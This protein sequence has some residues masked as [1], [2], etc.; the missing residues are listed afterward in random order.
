MILPTF[1]VGIYQW[2]IQNQWALL[3]YAVVI[4]IIV[5]LRKR[6][7]WQVFGIGLYKTKVGLKL[8]ERLGTKYRGLVQLL[9]Y[10]GVGVGFIGMLF[11]V[12][13]LLFGFYN[14]IANPAAPAVISPVL[15][16]FNIPGTELKVPLITGWIALFV[17]I[18]IHEFSHGVVS[19]AHKIRVK[20]SGLLVFG[21]IGGAFVEPDE[22]R[23]LKEQ[24]TVQ[25]SLFAA[26]PFSNIITAF[27]FVFLSAFIIAP[28]VLSMTTPVGV[29]IV[30]VTP[31]SPAANA[32]VAAG[33][34][35]TGVNGIA[36]TSYKEMGA[37]LD[38]VRPG[39]AVTV[40]TDKSASDASTTI[41]VVTGQSPSD[42]TSKKGYLGVNLRDKRDPKVSG[43]WFLGLLAI[44]NWIKDLLQW[45]VI[46]SLGIGLANLLPL[47]PVDGGRMLQIACQK[48][49]G[50]S[51]KHGR[52]DWWWRRIS[53][54]TFALII[55]LLL[56]PIV[57]AI[58]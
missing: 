58:I 9:G 43:P 50:D 12:Y 3:F 39:E 18:V 32:S 14:L 26:G 11:I 29:E 53:W 54:M 16:G 51:R 4:L 2:A 17:V 41:V 10:I 30:S 49:T 52:G 19:R 45:L 23:L 48:I 6:I 24:D 1:L 15:P 44:V 28:L 22:K 47:G 42:A 40:T 33:M 7:E 5:L 56:V 38:S 13:N 27:I 36:V 35:V 57:R 31:G 21:P 8:M 25:Y 20:S 34:V 46:L 37:Q 55:V